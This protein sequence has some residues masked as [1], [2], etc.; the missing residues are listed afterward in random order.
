MKKDF[1]LVYSDEALLNRALYL[2][3]PTKINIFVEDDGKEYRYEE[4]FERLLSDGV[5]ISCIFPTGGKQKLEE[6]YGLF[7]KSK[8][9]ENKTNILADKED[10]K[11]KKKKEKE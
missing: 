4:I 8:E 3:S 7:G 2:A 6:A 11:K 10:T 5:K 9:D 1:D